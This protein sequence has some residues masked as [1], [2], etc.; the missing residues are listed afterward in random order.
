[1]TNYNE[2]PNLETKELKKL[3]KRAR[4]SYRRIFIMKDEAYWRQYHPTDRKDGETWFS[5]AT[6]IKK[7][8]AS[9]TRIKYYVRRV[10]FWIGKRRA[11]N[12]PAFHHKAS[13]A[14]RCRIYS[15]LDHLP[16]GRTESHQE[17]YIAYCSCCKLPMKERL[18]RAQ[19]EAILVE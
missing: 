16:K 9:L 6:K 19:W 11:M 8:G 12:C 17:L 7:L 10:R 15:Q 5:L 3:L 4:R 13:W 2:I 1:M 18:K 14:V